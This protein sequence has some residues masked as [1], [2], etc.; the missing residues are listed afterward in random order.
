MLV[1]LGQG[2]SFAEL[3]YRF[4]GA[5][6]ATFSARLWKNALGTADLSA[7]GV[8]VVDVPI[9]SGRNVVVA[10]VSGTTQSGQMG[11]DSDRI[12]LLCCVPETEQPPVADAGADQYSVPAGLVFLDGRGSS[13]PN[14]DE[15]TYHWEQVSGPPGT[16]SD[17]NSP[18][19]SFLHFSAASASSSS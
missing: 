12:T 17:P 16:L 13:D 8:R 9:A 5:G 2:G 10:S 15:L 1:P 14:G 4:S 19:P 3:Q 11:R 18:T 7:Q 6:P